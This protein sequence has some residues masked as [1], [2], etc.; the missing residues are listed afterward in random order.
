VSAASRLQYAYLAYLSQPKT[1]RKLYRLLRARRPARIVELGLGTLERTLRML[2]VAERFA[3]GRKL[4][5]TGFDLFEA[6]PAGRPSLPLIAAHRRLKATSA[7]VKLIPGEPERT[8]RGAANTLSQIDLLLVAGDLD[9][10][11]MQETWHYVPRML[12]DETLVLHM[13]SPIGPPSIAPITPLDLARRLQA[14]PRRRA[15]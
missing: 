1:E 3:E 10:A 4:E 8:L 11:A 13:P 5:Y 9:D 12:G 14:F 7:R 2:R 15:A 6:R